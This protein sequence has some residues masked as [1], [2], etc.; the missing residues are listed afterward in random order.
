M[1]RRAFIGLGS[2]F[3]GAGAV[4]SSGAFDAVRGERSAAIRST[5]DPHAFLGLRNLEDPAFPPEFTNHLPNTLEIT[6]SSTDNGV[7]FDIGN[8]GDFSPVPVTFSL[9]PEQSVD[10][11]VNG[12]SVHV[13][14]DITAVEKNDGSNVG[15]IS[16]NRTFQVPQA[17]QV[18][19]T[20]DVK[21]A[22]SSGRFEFGLENTGSIDAWL[23]GMGIFEVDA[24]LEE[25]TITQVGGRNQDNI[26]EWTS[27]NNFQLLSDRMEI[28]SSEPDDGEVYTFDGG[29]DVP[30]L[31]EASGGEE[32]VF[33]FDRF[34]QA[35]DSN[36]D[37]R[38]SSVKI[39]LQF[40]DNSTTIDLAVDDGDD[41]EE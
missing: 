13:S 35:D 41:E 20:P 10:V 29:E 40:E 30:L 11:E 34:R 36:A 16:M 1:K 17:G 18:E 31:T 22:G 4:Y 27:N 25:G 8:D 24:P 38:E 7:E 39:F 23:T 37:M 28:D 14:V 6:L 33:R 12:D 5:G 26:L 3:I 2:A 21:S 32:E 19:I 9:E 15:E